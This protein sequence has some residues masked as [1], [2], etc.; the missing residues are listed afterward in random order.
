V[1]E[2]DRVP[3]SYFCKL[4]LS[5]NALPTCGQPLTGDDGDDG[6]GQVMGPAKVG[7]CPERLCWRPFAGG[8]RMF[9]LP[10]FGIEFRDEQAGRFWSDLRP[11]PKLT[12]L[13]RGMLLSAREIFHLMQ[14]H[15]NSC[16]TV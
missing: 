12:G 5:I 14:I 1:G 3:L 15:L 8:L 4:V 6:T 13:G 9:S 2:G 10:H 11:V 16:G 7:C